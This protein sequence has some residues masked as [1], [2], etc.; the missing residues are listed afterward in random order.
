MSKKAIQLLSDEKKLKLFKE[1]AI[2]Q[3]EQFDIDKVIPE[4]EELYNRFL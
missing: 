3:A 4:Y 1:N 2:K